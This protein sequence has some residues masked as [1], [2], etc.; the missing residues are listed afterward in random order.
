METRP[1]EVLLVARD[2][3]SIRPLREELR[4]RGVRVRSASGAEDG[5]PRARETR[6]ELVVLDEPAGEGDVADAMRSLCPEAEMI[7]LTGGAAGTP[8]GVGL[9][10]LLCSAKPVATGTLLEII[11]QAFPGRL[12]APSDPARAAGKVLCVDDDRDYLR[13]LERLLTRRGYRVRSCETARGALEALPEFEPDVAL[14]DVLMP[15]MDG[16]DLAR[17][18]V[19]TSHDRVPVV[20]LTALASE[21]LAGEG[22]RCGGRFVLAK[23]CGPEKLLDVVDYFAGD[24]DDSERESIKARL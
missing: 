22:R 1:L 3:S 14:L 5:L 8:S 17:E 6:P 13:S 12:R 18:I 21:E 2:A 9:G 7:V 16:L 23:P 15:G 4:R 24:L 11:D 20:F 10:L 19:R